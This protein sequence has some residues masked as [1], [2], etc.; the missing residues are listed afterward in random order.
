MSTDEWQVVASP[1][2]SRA[3]RAAESAPDD[4]ALQ[5]FA[6]LE[7]TEVLRAY[8]SRDEHKTA[9]LL[10]QVKRLL[11][12]VGAPQGVNLKS[13]YERLRALCRN[14]EVDRAGR[15]AFEEIMDKAW[16]RLE[17]GELEALLRS[18]PRQ[19]TVRVAPWSPKARLVG[20]APGAAPKRDKPPRDL[21]AEAAYEAQL[22]AYLTTW[23]S[24]TL[25]TLGLDNPPPRGVAERVSTTAF[26]A[27]R[28]PA[29]FTTSEL[30]GQ[31]V[32]WLAAKATRT[33][34]SRG[35][36]G[37]RRRTEAAEAASDDGSDAASRAAARDAAPQP[38]PAQPQLAQP[39]PLPAEAQA[40]AQPPP[41]QRAQPPLY[42]PPP[43]GPS[44]L[45]P[46][47]F[48]RSE[49]RGGAA[50]SVAAAPLVLPPQHS[51]LPPAAHARSYEAAVTPT[52]QESRLMQALGGVAGGERIVA[53]MRAMG[54]EA[55]DLLRLA[56]LVAAD[57][58]AELQLLGFAEPVTRARV[59]AALRAATETG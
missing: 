17:L 14:G 32:V 40:E 54:I 31:T 13:L 25:G 47:G 58:D 36:G 3:T 57:A 21:A 27:A 8:E 52:A 48:A 24:A 46:P 50:A 4:A 39:L 5:R 28:T 9:A 56:P 42:A 6:Q 34:G 20:L 1:A 43:S 30:R 37:R 51:I 41:P 2:R 38:P 15:P 19:F 7:L 12:D 16:Q 26:V 44:L 10:A 33:R 49:A 29:V 23:P 18:Q 11:I 59:R 55:S 53:H 22:V 45:P 35:E